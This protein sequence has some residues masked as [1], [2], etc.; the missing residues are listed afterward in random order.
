MSFTVNGPYYKPHC[1]QFAYGLR[2][3]CTLLALAC[4]D[5]I[6]KGIGAWVLDPHTPNPDPS[7][8]ANVQMVMYRI[9]KEARQTINPATNQPCCG[10]NGSAR[11]SDMVVMAHKI[12]MKIADILPYEDVQPTSAWVDFLR[13]NV[14]H[15]SRPRPVLVQFSNGRALRDAQS[16][17]T[18]EATLQNHAI[19]IY[20]TQTDPNNP[21]AGGYICCDGDNPGI[22]EHPVIYSLQTLAAARP[23]SMIAFDYITGGA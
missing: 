19:C 6:T 11:Q 8:A 15:N 17:G 21:E 20:G 9:Y 7:S 2:G 14:A 13:R 23:T 4:A 5:V 1:S 16:G 18:D 10:S 3:A 12:G 22:A